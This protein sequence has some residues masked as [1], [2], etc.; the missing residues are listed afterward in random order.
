MPTRLVAFPALDAARDERLRGEFVDLE[1]LNAVDQA[2]A[3]AAMPEADAFFGKITPELLAASQ[4][5]R[6]VQSPTASL[7]H[8]LFPALVEHPSVLTNMRGIFSDVIADHVFGYLLCF[9]RN[10]HRYVRQ[11]QHRQWAPVGS[12]TARAD[13]SVGPGQVSAIDTAHRDLPGATL[14]IVGFGEIGREIACRA[15]AFGMRVLAVDARRQGMLEYRVDCLPVAR[16]PELLAASDYV[17]IAAPHTPETERMFRRE[18]LR[19]MKPTA[20]LV[21]IGRGAIV[22]LDDLVAA[23]AAGEIAGAA[24]DVFENEPLP[25]EHPLWGMENVIL[26]PHIAGASARVAAR[27]FDVLRDNIGR[28]LSGKPLLNIVDKQAWY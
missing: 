8:Y 2:A 25:A 21:N 7:E 16:L 28:F 15:R 10:L 12:E 27:H 11:Q 22:V 20:Y 23:I 13:F 26:T 14:G 19:Q 6:W 4:R 17:V 18:Q 24:L 3:L 1:L 5:L 9:A